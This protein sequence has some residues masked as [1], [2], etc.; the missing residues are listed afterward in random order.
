MKNAHSRSSATQQEVKCGEREVVL[1]KDRNLNQLCFKY[2]ALEVL[3]RLREE[4]LRR[5]LALGGTVK[6]LPHW[7]LGKAALLR[8]SV[9]L[10]TVYAL[11]PYLMVSLK[12]S[13]SGWF[14]SPW[15]KGEEQDGL[16]YFSQK[17]FSVLQAFPNAPV[18]GW[19]LME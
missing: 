15:F 6:P 8:E 4:G 13:L 12:N 17:L 9:C 14:L 1:E 2:L 16:P 3:Q 7:L 18:V 11:V 10:C 5:G 19:P